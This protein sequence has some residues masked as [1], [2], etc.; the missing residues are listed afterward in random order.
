[1]TKIE[2]EKS[3]AEQLVVIPP[4]SYT[5]C[6]RYDTDEFHGLRIRDVVGNEYIITAPLSKRIGCH[7]VKHSNM[8]TLC[9]DCINIPDSVECNY[10][11]NT[12]KYAPLYK[13]MSGY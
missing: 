10:I 5:T 11:L 2:S 6:I 12:F 8:I 13:G 1:M 9:K 7:C 4:G 3:L